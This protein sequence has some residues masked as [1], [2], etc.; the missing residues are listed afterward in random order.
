MLI[1][2]THPA[3]NIAALTIDR[4][5]K[6][7]ALSEELLVELAEKLEQE[8]SSAAAV[9]LTGAGSAFS[10]G[11]DLSAGDPSGI[12]PALKRVVDLI[13]GAD[14]AVVAYVNGPAIGA[15]AMLAGA[16]DIR[17]IAPQARFAIPVAKMGV[18]VPPELA[19]EF[20][21][22][23]GGARARTMLMTGMPMNS[24][25]AVDCGFAA[26]KG[27]F[28]DA[29]EAAKVCAAGSPETIASI[30]KAFFQ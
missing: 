4:D 21:R 12:Y 11:A 7:N 13:R 24:A 28:D 16:C 10:A 17:V 14:K 23:V 6:R 3:E 26:L 5:E 15:G 20:A 1:T 25:T 2:V 22:L 19:H 8:L 18:P 27:T 9:V 30:K 29:V